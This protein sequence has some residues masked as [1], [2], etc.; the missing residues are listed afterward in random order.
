[1]A[2]QPPSR[3]EI[4]AVL[5]RVLALP[6]VAKFEI[7]KELQDDLSAAVLSSPKT[8]MIEQRNET[9]RAL[10]EAREHLGLP[11]G[12][13][14][15]AKQFDTAAKALKLPWSSAAVIR[16][17]GRWSVAVDVYKGERGETTTK[18]RQPRRKRTKHAADYLA[19]TLVWLES[20]PEDLSRAS[21]D[22]FALKY[23]LSVDLDDDLSTGETISNSLSLRWANVLAVAKGE[24]TRDEAGEQ[25]LAET[26]PAKV[27]DALLGVQGIAHFLGVSGGTVASQAGEDPLF[28][29]AV[30]HIQNKRAWL[31][32]DIK[33]YKRGLPPPKRTEGEQ[34]FL[35]VDAIE[36]AARLEITRNALR[37]RIKRK[38]WG[39]VPKPEGAIATGRYYWKRDK[40]EAWLK[41]K[42]EIGQ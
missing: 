6:D 34:Q 28:P 39:K 25:E 18:R 5:Q 4:N 31:Y 15:T 22:S 41:A 26:L 20:K 14:P 1:M 11:V 7:F 9:L 12:T 33:L 19:D 16:L 24:L 21:Y 23:N 38:T 30:A 27:K 37:I 17:W 10:E 40:V 3:I 32:E 8:R 36:L 29:V 42:D 13:P 2:D 35:F